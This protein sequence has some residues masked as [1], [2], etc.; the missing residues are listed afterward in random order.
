[1][2]S[3]F[4]NIGRAIGSISLTQWIFIALILGFCIG[5]WAPALVPILRPFR[6]LFL[7]G[8]KCIIAPLIISTIVSGIAG[9]GSFRQ[10]GM[11]GVRAFI[12]FEV[13]T[14][15]ALIVGLGVVNILRPGDGIQLAAAP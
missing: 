3:A 2:K 6:G 8:I 14:T 13:A 1:M 11:M 9:A 12:Y 7:N 5:A 15:L 4:K 10:L